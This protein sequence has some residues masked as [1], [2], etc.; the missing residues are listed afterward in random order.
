MA[1]TR[2]ITIATTRE[3][4]AENSEQLVCTR[5]S[6]ANKVRETA[7]DI[8]KCAEG[9][10]PGLGRRD[11]GWRLRPGGFLWAL[12]VFPG[13]AL[14]GCAATPF[15]PGYYADLMDPAPTI[16]ATWVPRT[17]V[18][19]DV[20]N[21]SA[22]SIGVAINRSDRCD[23][24]RT[25]PIC[26]RR[27]WADSAPS[28]IASGRSGVPAKAAI[29]LRAR[30]SLHRPKRALR[31]A[32]RL[33]CRF[34]DA[35]ITRGAPLAPARWSR[36]LPPRWETKSRSQR[37]VV[38]V[39]R[40]AGPKETPPPRCRHRAGEFRS[41]RWPAKPPQFD[42]ACFR[43]AEFA[44]SLSTPCARRITTAFRRS[45]PSH[46]LWRPTHP[47]CAEFQPVDQ[48]DHCVVARRRVSGDS[49][50]VASL[51]MVPGCSCACAAL[52]NRVRQPGAFCGGCSRPPHSDSLP[53]LRSSPT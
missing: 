25:L 50:I 3:S 37:I 51:Q 42:T 5:R 47:A 39:D 11:S 1:T 36:E 33:L 49:P 35:G 45:H 16:A 30:N 13:L 34:L 22:P 32:R 29:P 26:E 40:W 9:S 10:S 44:A 31:K 12:A 17:L 24:Q 20:A 38:A 19:G 27:N 28:G 8:A 46:T 14:S 6:W 43:Q 2:A 52:A 23:A 4:T 18:P 48:V 7:N 15:Y 53:W 41:P 21:V